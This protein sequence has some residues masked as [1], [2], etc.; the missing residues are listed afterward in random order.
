VNFFSFICNNLN[1][2]R[3]I[4]K[5]Y[6]NINNIIYMIMVIIKNYIIILIIL[7][8]YNYGYNNKID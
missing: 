1:K 5:L 6:N 3:I 2:I 8:I 7:Y 4:I